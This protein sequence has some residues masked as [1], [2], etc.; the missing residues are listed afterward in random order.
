MRPLAPRHQGRTFAPSEW[1]DGRLTARLQGVRAGSAPI[2]AA[3]LGIALLT[4]ACG[5]GAPA[6]SSG[7]PSTNRVGSTLTTSTTTTAVTTPPPTTTTTT[8]TTIPPLAPPAALAPFAPGG[9]ANEGA[10][11][12]AG[13]TVGA[14]VA[15]YE[16]QLV[17]PEGSLA[18]G[19]AW[20]DTKLLSAQL[21]SG[22][23][24]PG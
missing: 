6:R 22:S 14:T 10:W 16:T 4:A 2:V 3:L 23:K 1:R 12:A 13:R 8:T 5:V 11:T 19:I 9:P 21:Y 15:V 7:H 18:A 17:P 24:S 20:M